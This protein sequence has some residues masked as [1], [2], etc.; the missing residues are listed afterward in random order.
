MRWMNTQQN[1]VT[2]LNRSEGIDIVNL[3][4]DIE[5]VLIPNSE[6]HH[7]EQRRRNRTPLSYNNAAMVVSVLV[8]SNERWRRPATSL[9]NAA[10]HHRYGGQ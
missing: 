9:L 8:T 10:R 5:T 1:T 7:A 6:N 3:P 4:T 2:T